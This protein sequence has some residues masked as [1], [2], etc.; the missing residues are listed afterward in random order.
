MLGTLFAR[1]KRQLKKKQGSGSGGGGGN[2]N[3]PPVTNNPSPTTPPPNPYIQINSNG[4]LDLPYDQQFA[5]YLLDAQGSMNQ[6]LLQLQQQSQMQ[7]LEYTQSKRDG[8]QDY[9][10]IARQ[11]LNQNAARGLAHSSAYGIDVADNANDYMKWNQDIDQANGLHDA[12]VTAERNAIETQFNGMLQRWA[13]EQAEK[14][15]RDAGNLGYGKPGTQK[16]KPVKRPGSGGGNNSGGGN[17][18]KPKPRQPKPGTWAAKH[19]R[20]NRIGPA[21]N[22]QRPKKAPPKGK[23]WVPIRK[24]GKIVRWKIVA[25]KGGN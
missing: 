23:R 1:N 10:D 16:P 6:R 3:P 24:G 7:D 9:Q 11:V 2:S 14:K 25:N 17:K 22:L 12:G 13:L 8:A 20:S 21:G 4:Q 19:N 15:A 5:S 18:P